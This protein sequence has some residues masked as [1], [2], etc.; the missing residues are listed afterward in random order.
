MSEE[1][2]KTKK[3]MTKRQKALR[4]RLIALITIVVVAIVAVVLVVCKK[5]GVF[6]ERAETSTLTI[7][8]DGTVICEEVTTFDESFYD[9]AQLKKFVKTE[10]D[11]YNKEAGDSEIK[12]NSLT[13]KGETAY[14]KTTY[15]TVDDYCAFTGIELFAGSMSQAKKAYDFA[16]AFVTVKEGVKGTSAEPLD[17]TSQKKLKVLVVKENINVSV[18]GEI[19]YVSDSSTSMIDNHTVAIAQPDGN[20]DATQLTY[21]IY[22]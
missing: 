10:I 18:D 8:K 9:K 16:D 14:A 19:L 4:N 11:N 21:I 7:T 6:D 12:L 3:G 15:K 17:I 5:A 20:E 1:G 22:K 2:K 13:V